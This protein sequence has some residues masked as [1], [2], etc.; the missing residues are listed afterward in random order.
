M[1][2]TYLPLLTTDNIVR[3]HCVLEPSSPVHIELS[4]GAV[5]TSL[6]ETAVDLAFD[7]PVE[8]EDEATLS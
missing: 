6:E 5:A 2:E 3:V 8:L 4:T 7:P 1:E